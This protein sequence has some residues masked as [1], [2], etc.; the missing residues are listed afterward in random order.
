MQCPNLFVQYP[1]LK[2]LVE[3]IRD[4]SGT[5]Y[6]IGGS[7]R[8]LLL[9]QTPGD[10][11]IEVFGVEHELLDQQLRKKFRVDFVGKTFGVFKLKGLPIDV[12]LPRTERAIG[13]KH[14]DFEV[15][16]D[17]RLSLE[18][19]ASRR[20]F[21]INSIYLNL[22]TLK[23]EDPLSGE[24][25]LKKGILRHSSKQ[26]VEDP[27]R[28]L[29]A[30]QF[31]SRFDLTCA[32][33]TLEICRSMNHRHLPKERIF[34]EFK[35]LILKG[36]N[37]RAGLQ[38]LAD[39][40]WI[41]MFPELEALIGCEQ[42]AQW[43]P[44]GDVWQHTLLSMNAFANRRSG[45]SKEDLIIGLAVLCHDLGKP[46]TTIHVDGRIRS[47]RH[48]VEG[49]AP[50]VSFLNRL[51]DERKL[52][53]AVP[54]LVKEHMAPLALQK[55]KAGDAAVRRLAIRVGRLDRL[56]RVCRADREGR[57]D[58]WEPLPSPEVEWL[59]EKMETLQLSD[60]TPKPIL[61]GRDLIE[62][63]FE[64][65]KKMGD[66]LKQLFEA[67]LDGKFFTREEGIAYLHENCKTTQKSS[68]LDDN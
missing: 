10:L 31:I 57:Q 8:D 39:C 2:G 33:E 6:L 9:G 45:D 3:C 34:E 26:Y 66:L 42:D 56:M 63:G 12:S 32:P 16:L 7:V 48:D 20:D 4:I 50:T 28:V 24:E 61:F 1:F 62:L 49:I 67:Q 30:M 38:F 55:N 60:K 59:I 18:Q 58:P 54:P 29:R 25:D 35:K 44:E 13:G 52:L 65:G 47:P 40:R 37:I 23:I 36:K 43:H 68:L 19:A 21:T 27:L 14:T 17:P 22:N 53:E 64:P 5:P 41:S 46:T 51:T 15:M 11:D